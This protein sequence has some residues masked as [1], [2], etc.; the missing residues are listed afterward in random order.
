MDSYT[1]STIVD[2]ESLVWLQMLYRILFFI[3]TVA[4]APAATLTTTCIDSVGVVTLN[5]SSAVG[6]P[7]IHV[8][9]A[10]GTL[11]TGALPASGTA[12][13]G[14][15]VSQG[16]SFFLVDQSGIVEASVTANTLCSSLPPTIDQG[17]GSGSYFPLAVGNTWVYKYNSRSVTATYIVQTITGITSQ[18]GQ[19]YY[20][21]TETSPPDPTPVAM[22]RADS[23]TGIIYQF[24]STG[25]QVY[26]DPRPSSPAPYSGALGVFNDA[27]YPPMQLQGSLIQ[28]NSVYAR[29]IGLV[30]SES[31]MLSGSSGGFTQSLELVDVKVNGF[32]LSVPQPK[33]ALSID[34]PF[35][36][37]TNEK[38]PNC[39]IPCYFPACGIAGADP[40]G[41]YRPCGQIRVDASAEGPSY[42]VL[43]QLLDST[44]APVFQNSTQSLATSSLD[45]IRLP[46]YTGQTPFKPL[47]PGNYT[48]V[49]TVILGST[50]LATSTIAVQIH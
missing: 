39:A 20:V 47:P 38:A 49:G 40:T 44:G 23:T 33:I 12:I 29:G 16:L 19:T 21:L 48:L 6:Q 2:A 43:V 4:L 17:L 18:N 35:P 42:S 50:T 32:H 7:Q 26:L 13:T 15:W 31:I 11:L 25:E 9:T 22:L 46:L 10:T 45:Y 24:T 27:I 36:D 5:W 37:L 14:P 3:L 8:G 34:N 30:N 28:T 41:T 1:L